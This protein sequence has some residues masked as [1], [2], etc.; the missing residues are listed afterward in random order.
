MVVVQARLELKVR[1]KLG[2]VVVRDVHHSIPGPDIVW[3]CCRMSQNI[4][5]FWSSILSRNSQL[6]TIIILTYN[7]GCSSLG[8]GELTS[9]SCIGL[10]I[11]KKYEFLSGE[12]TYNIPIFFFKCVLL[13]TKDY[14]HQQIK[15]GQVWLSNVTVK[16]DENSVCETTV[17]KRRK[18]N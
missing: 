12:H 9:E 6:S 8:N 10:A 2:V 5:L 4:F 15:F 13:N 11:Q 7:W 17:L 18:V 16:L 1:D 14:I 3:F